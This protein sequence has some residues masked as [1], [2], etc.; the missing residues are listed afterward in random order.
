M[1]GER[2]LGER[3]RYW[4]DPRFTSSERPP[5]RQKSNLSLGS[6]RWNSRYREKKIGPRGDQSLANT[7]G[8]EARTF[9]FRNFPEGCGVNTLKSKFSEVGEVV[10]IFCPN[11]RDRA[12][13]P[14]GFVRLLASQI[15]DVE[16]TL[17]KLNR[18][19]ID[20]YK[21][22]VYKPR[23]ERTPMPNIKTQTRNGFA[24]NLGVRSPEKTYRDAIR[25]SGFEN[26]GDTHKEGLQPKVQKDDSFVFSP[27]AEERNWLEKCWIGLLKNDF[28][29]EDN[30][31]EIQGECGIK[32]KL[33]YMGDNVVL[34]RNQSEFSL[35]E[36]EKEMGEWLKNWFQWVRPWKEQDVCHRRKERLDIAR[37]QLSVP[38]DNEINTSFSVRIGDHS[39]KIRIIEEYSFDDHREDPY[40]EDDSSSNLSGSMEQYSLGPAMADIH[41]NNHLAGDSDDELVSSPT[42][43]N[44]SVH[45]KEGGDTLTT[46]YS[47]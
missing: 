24:A 25:K 19:W 15:R 35:P 38:F 2:K 43:P 20:S 44:P 8:R 4:V 23:F 27:T 31:E 34:I 21:L 30:G 9:F 32:F 13:K 33:C 1:T 22:C 40:E 5:A 36:F 41:D 26:Q 17:V 42:N 37:L 45:P 11:K 28:T 29:W 18:L 7:H 3:V 47:P 14:Y 10:D 16:A 12:G 6:E 39:F 46:T